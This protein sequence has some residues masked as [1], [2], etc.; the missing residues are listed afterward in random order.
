[1]HDLR[2]FMKVIW[3]DWV[4]LMSGIGSVLLSILGAIWVGPNGLPSWTFWVAAVIC[5]LIC[6]FRVWQNERRAREVA[7]ARLRA[8]L[9]ISGVALFQPSDDHRRVLVRNLT[10]KS[11]RFRA[12]LLETRPKIQYILPVHLRPTHGQEYEEM[13]VEA[14]GVQPVDVFVDCGAPKPLFLLL[15]GNPPYGYQ[16]C[17]KERL[18]LCIGVYPTSEEGEGDQ[19][20]FYIVPQPD[21][22]VIFTVA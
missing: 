16:L 18:E 3:G 20:W 5:F 17:R 13:S 12:K 14:N 21:G 2:A 19:H 10:G 15:M 22:S 1:M 7:E 6:S 11:V 8:K 9:R 4:A